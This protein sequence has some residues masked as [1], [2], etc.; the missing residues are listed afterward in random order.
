ME[1]LL[2]FLNGIL[3]I[4]SEPQSLTLGQVALRASTIYLAGWLMIRVGEHRFLGKNTAFDI[5]LGFIFG[6]TLA[7]AI[8][9]SAP[10]FETIAAGVVLLILHWLFMTLAY[11]SDRLDK[12]LNGKAHRIIENGQILWD[13]MRSAR[14][15]ARLLHENLRTNGNIR[16]AEDVAEADYEPSGNI[17]VIPKRKEYRVVEVDVR[18]GVQTVRV[19]FTG[20]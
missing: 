15:N 1:G 3:G 9:G 12:V 11:H 2:Q 18:N 10:F 4:G 7:R 8:N 13:Q 17:S 20:E 14:I 16:S 5:V 6:T 19:E